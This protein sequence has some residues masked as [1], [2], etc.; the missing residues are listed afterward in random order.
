MFPLTDL[1]CESIGGEV[2]GFV[3]YMVGPQKII[4]S[5]MGNKL[6]SA[7]H[8]TNTSLIGRMDAFDEDKKEDLEKHHSDGDR[9]FWVKA[10][11]D[12]ASALSLLP[13]GSTN[14]DTDGSL[15][16]ATAFEE[17][18]SSTPPAMKGLSEGNVAG[19]LN[20]QRIQQSFVQLQGFVKNYMHFLR[21]RAKLWMYYWQTYFKDEEVFKVTQKRHP[22]DPEYFAINQVAVDDYGELSIKNDI[23]AGEYD[24]VIEDSYQSPTVRD[25]VRQQ[26]IELQNSPSIQQDPVLN[27]MLTMYFLKMSDAPQDLKDYAIKH[28]AIVAQ[29][30]Q[31]LAQQ[32]AQQAQQASAQGQQAMRGERLNQVEQQQRIAQSEAEQTFD[33]NNFPPAQV[34]D[35]P[36]NINIPRP[37]SATSGQGF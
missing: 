12:P 7:K 9:T 14:P 21:R 26:I 22:D 30:Q 34:E 15:N 17:E 11:Q 37:Q 23:T 20:E 13:Q 19:V 33:P 35:Q 36:L 32:E 6:H 3:E 18:V 4:N 31:R 28:S 24:M 5:M 8:S 10:G 16:Y 2:N 25:K 27:T 29:E 1:I